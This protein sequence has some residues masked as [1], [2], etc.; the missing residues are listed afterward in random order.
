MECINSP[1]PP[2]LKNQNVNQFESNDYNYKVFKIYLSLYNLSKTIE[3]KLAPDIQIKEEFYLIH[4]PWLKDFKNKFNYKDLEEK[5]FVEKCESIN[6]DSQLNNEKIIIELFRQSKFD[7]RKIERNEFNEINRIYN[8]KILVKNKD[9]IYY[10]DYAIITQK[11][12]EEIKKNNFYF[13]ERP[14]IDINLGNQ[15]F[16]L[17]VGMTGLECVF[18]KDYDCFIDE[19]LIIYINSD[20]RNKAEKEIISF[21]LQYYFNVNQINTNTYEEQYIFDNQNIKIATVICLNSNKKKE[22]IENVNKAIINLHYEALSDSLKGK[23]RED[24]SVLDAAT[25]LTN[26]IIDNMKNKI[27]FNKENIK[28]ETLLKE[29]DYKNINYVTN[30][31]NTKTIT[32]KQTIILSQFN[33]NNKLGLI[34]LGNSCYINAVLQ[35]L[36]HIPEIVK[37]FLRSNFDFNY[38]PLSWILNFLVQALYIPLNINIQET[39]YNPSYI[40]MIIFQLNKNF[41]PYQ[42]ND[43]KDFLIY[44]IGRLHQELNQSENNQKKNYTYFNIVKRDDPLSSFINYFASNYR[45]IISDVFNWTNQVRRICSNCKSQIL[46]YQT[47]PYLILDLENTRKNKYEYNF[48]NKYDEEEKNKNYSLQDYKK[49]FN[50]YYE[51][52]ENIPIELID[53]IKY[54]YEKKNHFDFFCPYCNNFCGQT[55]TNRIYLSPNIFIF[56][57]NRGKNNIYSVKMNYPGILEIGK[58]IECNQTPNKYELIGVIT[59]LGLSGPGGHFIAFCKDPIDEKWYR[60]NDEK[61]TQAEKASIFNEGIAYILF[62]RFIKN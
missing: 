47:F 13:D 56:I 58:Y 51:K 32:K 57:L 17:C 16:I 38:S 11:I 61:I 33:P 37:Y 8:K 15:S 62:Y 39:A 54:Y 41:S 42:P 49:Q 48:K 36:F 43:A 55:S 53:C 10:N 12:S 34:N 40:C 28:K 3:K 52:K 2:C 5:F 4:L 22:I 26:K 1:P 7:Q 30:I 46:S 25:Q 19:Y 21:G 20:F 14:K 18:C 31:F 24:E 35:C 6:L 27:H 45:S 60:Y 59:H 9:F 23:K 50:E 44:I 29:F